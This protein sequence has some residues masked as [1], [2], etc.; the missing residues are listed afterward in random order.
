[1]CNLKFLAVFL[2]VYCSTAIAQQTP[3]LPE[4]LKPGARITFE[5]GNST[6]RGTRLVPADPKTGFIKK[7]NDWFKLEQGQSNGG[8]GYTQLN[9][10]AAS[11]QFI[12]ADAQVFVNIDLANN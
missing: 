1:M 6:L 11:P 2:F 5:G 7:G 4:F 12:A 10:Q 9:I 8:V 3:K